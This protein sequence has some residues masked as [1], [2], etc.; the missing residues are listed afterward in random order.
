MQLRVVEMKGFSLIELLTSVAIV[1]ILYTLVSPSLKS[2]VAKARRAEAKTILNH[3]DTLQRAYKE[4]NG[5]YYAIT[6]SKSKDLNELHRYG[7]PTTVLTGVTVDCHPNGLYFKVENCNKLRYQYYLTNT[8]NHV[9][10]AKAVA[11]H[12]SGMPTIYP[13]CTLTS[14]SGDV[15]TATSLEIYEQP[16]KDVIKECQK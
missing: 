14:G 9:Y 2:S 8:S 10:E 12:R 15:W 11:P 7:Q 6:K 3:I 13:N 1:G 5:Y 16:T 4:D